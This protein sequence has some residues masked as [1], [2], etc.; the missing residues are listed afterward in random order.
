MPSEVF[1]HKIGQNWAIRQGETTVSYIYGY[2]YSYRC[3]HLEGDEEEV[4]EGVTG[5]EGGEPLGGQVDVWQRGQGGELGEQ[6][7]T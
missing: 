4:E 3:P 7:N 2:I 1:P 5:P 6:E